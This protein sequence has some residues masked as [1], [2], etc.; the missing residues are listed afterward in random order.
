MSEPISCIL[1]GVIVSLIGFGCGWC[2]R[3]ESI[4]RRVRRMSD[5]SFG[6]SYRSPFGYPLPPMP[7]RQSPKPPQRP[8]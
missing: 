7:P 1:G 8:L 4:S 2:A 5:P 6:A 3:G